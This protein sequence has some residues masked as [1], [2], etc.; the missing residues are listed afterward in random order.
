MAHMRWTSGRAQVELSQMLSPTIVWPEGVDPRQ[1]GMALLQALGLSEAD[2]QRLSRTIDWTSTLV[3]PLPTNIASF[4][5]VEVD[6]ANGVMIESASGN[7]GESA[8]LWQRDGILY[9]VSGRGVERTL[10]LQIA[11]SLR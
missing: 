1:L 3:I 6:G 2:A 9:V 7:S 5:E 8:I 10:L 4:R 11:G